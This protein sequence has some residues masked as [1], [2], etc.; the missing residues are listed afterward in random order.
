[1]DENTYG[2]SLA[3]ATE[4]VNSIG[5]SERGFQEAKPRNQSPKTVVLNADLDAAV[6]A[7]TSASIEEATV[8][9]RTSGGNLASAGYVIDVVNRSEHIDLKQY[10]L[11]IATWIDGEWRITSA[12][13]DPLGNWP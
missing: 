12:D 11:C 6:D 1:M 2:F 8:L 5:S 9:R 10:T 7:L 13:C 3:D 4:L